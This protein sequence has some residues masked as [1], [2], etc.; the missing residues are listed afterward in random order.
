MLY[1]TV[2]TQTGSTALTSSYPSPP[3]T[4]IQHKIGAVGHSL[5][6]RSS[7]RRNVERGSVDVS[8][9]Y[10]SKEVGQ[11]GRGRGAGRGEEGEGVGYKKH[12]EGSTNK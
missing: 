5:P 1:C 10:Y 2:F 4:G 11:V 6:S 12:E 9:S 3:P 7:N 8:C